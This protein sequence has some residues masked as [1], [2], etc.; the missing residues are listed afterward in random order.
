[1]VKMWV[2]LNYSTLNTINY[3]ISFPQLSL[4]F[5]SESLSDSILGLKA[6]SFSSN[7]LPIAE[8]V[9]K[10]AE[11]NTAFI[12]Y[13]IMV[14]LWPNILNFYKS[15]F[16]PQDSEN[17]FM[18]LMNKAFQLRYEH[19]MERNDILSH[20]MKIREVHKLKESDMYSHTMTFLID[21][22]DTTA[23]VISHCLLMVSS[24][25]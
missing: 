20:L 3:H 14:G 5:T 24:E 1:M 17:F 18:N 7:P 19:N 6:H 13:T 4:R 10:F 25:N 21:G 16:F 15:K 2:S 22:L 11:H 23:T 12:I 9:R 8:N